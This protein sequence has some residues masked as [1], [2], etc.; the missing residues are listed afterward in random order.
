M[1]DGALRIVVLGYVVGFP[2]GGMTWHTLQYPMGLAALGHD[3]WVVEDSDDY[4][5]CYD[6][7]TGQ[8][9]ADP[10]Y[11]LRYA[12]RV[13]DRVGLGA[14]WAYHD[15]HTGTWHGPAS[16]RI[17]QVCGTADVVINIA[18]IHP[19]RPWLTDID[20][21]VFVDADPAFTQVRHLTDPTA[22]A[23]AA[24]HTAHATFGELIP[25][26][27]SAVPD[28]GFAWVA[29]RQPIVLDAWP[30]TPPPDRGRLTTVMQWDSYRPAVHDGVEYGM[31][32]ASFE[33]Y[34]ELPRRTCAA[35]ELALGRGRDR[36]D[37]LR[38]AGWI[39]SNPE[40]AT[41]DPWVY[42]RY[43]AASLGEW[44]VAKHGYVRARTGWFSERTAAYLASGRPAVVQDTGWSRTLPS[45]EGL[46]AFHDPDS[47][48][49]AVDLVCRDP[50]G[51]GH[52]ARE[53]AHA[54]FDANTVLAQLLA[55]T[56]G[57]STTAAS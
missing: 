19:L 33:P 36:V 10:A 7:S 11:G 4:E 38:E 24:A 8:V 2:L 44:S 40:E 17:L 48:A 3:V 30:V 49:T 51:H 47:A 18:G 54:H 57:R 35:M 25:A 55:D 23:H 42:Q 31:K 46:L 34:V 37:E 15:S 13:Y 32:S 39:I 56:V 43:L 6:P 41:A 5:T 45:G 16:D 14:R 1:T 20:D 28:D 52:R 21:R 50:A 53:V 29:T 27:R 26:G 9:G 22:A 12:A